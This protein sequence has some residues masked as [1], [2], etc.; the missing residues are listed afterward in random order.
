MIVSF[1]V[2]NTIYF[3]HYDLIAERLSATT[4]CSLCVQCT[5]FKDD[6]VKWV[7]LSPTLHYLAI[8]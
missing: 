3:Y 8:M 7:A 1:Q 5:S 6:Q 2:T 4:L